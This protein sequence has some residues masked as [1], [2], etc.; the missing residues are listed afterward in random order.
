M[1]S[2]TL[3]T[4]ALFDP[5]RDDLAAALSCAAPGGWAAHSGVQARVLWPMHVVC[6]RALDFQAPAWTDALRAAGIDVLPRPGHF[7]GHDL[8]V[9]WSR[10]TECLALTQDKT[11]A[12]AL[13]DSLR[14]GAWALGYAA[15]RSTGM[16]AVELGG[17][18]I[19]GLLKRLVDAGSIPMDPGRATRSRMI[20]VGVYLMRLEDQKL[21]LLV[22]RAHADYLS[23]WLLDASQRLADSVTS[24][25][26]DKF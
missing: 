19:D 12:V 17:A 16:I 26:V 24:S 14:P 4:L 8:R 15:D 13:L 22:D 3:E 10:P 18:G 2:E 21:W 23:A 25:R 7:T 5:V 6:L 20:D 11:T 9:V 1:A